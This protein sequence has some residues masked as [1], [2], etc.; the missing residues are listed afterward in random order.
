MSVAG[1][2][3]GDDDAGVDVGRLV[4]REAELAHL[5]AWLS[6]VVAGRSRPLL[7]EGEPGV[8]K[9]SLLHAARARA[10]AHGM[11]TVAVTA[12]P[13]AANLALAC[14]GAVVGPLGPIDAGLDPSAIGPLQL[15]LGDPSANVNPLALCGALVALLAAAAEHEPIV[16]IIDD[17]QWADASS[18]DVI[19]AAFQGLALDQVGLLVASAAANRIRSGISSGYRSQG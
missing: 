4:G 19:V 16:I 5:D 15:A 7:L 3:P 11:G 2:T 12:I 18:V 1:A 13:A 6:S 10:R 14:L 9:T 8:G 17:G